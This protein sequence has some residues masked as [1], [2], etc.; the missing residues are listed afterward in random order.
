[1]YDLTLGKRWSF[2]SKEQSKKNHV[3]FMS[4]AFSQINHP[5]DQFGHFSQVEALKNHDFL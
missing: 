3:S 4:H 1:M 2:Q 5:F